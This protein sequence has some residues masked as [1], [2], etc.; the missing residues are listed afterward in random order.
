[1]PDAADPILKLSGITKRFGALVANDDIS[2]SLHAGEIVALLGENGA[3]K[4]TLVSILFGHYTADQG[5]IDVFG[6]PLPPGDPAAALARGVGM[7]HQHFAL[8]ENLTVLEN[9]V[10]GTRSLFSPSLRKGRVAADI[11]TTAERF[12][13]WVDPQA[14]VGDLSVG[15]RQ[16]VEI[17][18]ALYRGARILILDEPTAVLTPQESE[19]LFD[20][21]QQLVGQGLAIIFISHKLDEVVRV[22]DRIAVLRGGKLVAQVARAQASTAHLAEL[23]VGRQVDKVSRAPATNTSTDT[24]RDTTPGCELREAQVRQRNGRL[25]LDQVDLAAGSGQIIGIAGVSGNGQATLANVLSGT[26][27][28]DS[29]SLRINGQAVPADPRAL[30]AQNVARIPE[31]RHAI[32]VIG[33]LR[34]WENTI[35]ERYHTAEFS[36]LGWLRR[37]QARRKAEAIVKD[38]DVRGLQAQGLETTTRALSGGNMQKLILGRALT[39]TAGTPRLIIANQPTW[40]L[41]VGAVALVH[42][43]LL[44][45]AE[46]GAAV[47]VISEDLDEL[48]ALAS[49]IAVMHAGRLSAPR[50]AADWTMAAIGAAMAG[51]EAH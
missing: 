46:A 34:I 39:G 50:P 48:F 31:D 41:D 7:V 14:R 12:G 21:L 45:A 44:A 11:K 23:M 16:R 40:G 18:K 38:F 30:T 4:S 17:L 29:G 28:L 20:T 51:V 9:I 27:A 33:E 24:A 22:S 1:M 25:L 47:I 36:R 19:S 35:L 6:E 13:L 42:R 32:G 2:L 5:T 3:G 37:G 26:Q 43:Q 15:E 10:A 8:A 49:D